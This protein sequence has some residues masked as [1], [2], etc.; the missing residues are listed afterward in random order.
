[1]LFFSGVTEIALLGQPR[2]QQIGDAALMSSS[3][4]PI[5]PAPSPAGRMQIYRST[6]FPAATT[7]AAAT[8]IAI[9][10]GEERSDVTITLRPVPAM[11]VS[12]RLVTPNGSPAAFITIRLVG[13]A[14]AGVIDSIGS[15]G[16][17]MET[18][19]GMSDSSGRFTLLGVPPGDYVLTH[20]NAFLSRAL[21]DG[22]PAYSIAHPVTV[23]A[24]DLDLV[25]QARP[26][27]RVEGRAEYRGATTAHPP[28]PTGIT[29]ETPFGE[30]GQFS[31]AAPNDGTHK[32]ATIAAAGQ[33]I[34]RPYERFKWFVQ[35]VTVGGKDIT[36]RVFD[37]Q[38]DT[39]SFVV[40]YTNQP[41][42]VSGT[43]IDARGA[44]SPNAV[45]LAFPVDRRRWTGYGMTPRILQSALTT[46]S[47]DYTF[48][49]LPAGDYYVI[50]I[51]AADMDDWKDPARL[52]VLAGE[53]SR[54][55]VAATDT[56]KTL[57]L[58]VKAVQ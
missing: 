29:F 7:A 58:R 20:A 16:Q 12:G 47:G 48:D 14:K 34:A 3:R 1:M 32:F 30:P 25:V 43:V 8:P 5:P 24:D 52:E 2:T 9:V 39:T 54:L 15:S 21:Q 44:A 49:H 36:D 33:Y 26:A 23:G 46:R 40:T 35:S 38:A 51:D 37:L 13:D 19:S 4:V 22:T 53:A 27:L 10:A 28:A 6:Y 56:V 45:V 50:A 17:G 41:S 42:K 11:R 57:D 55:T 18:V 31:V